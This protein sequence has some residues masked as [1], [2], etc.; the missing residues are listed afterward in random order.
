MRFLIVVLY[1]D[2]LISTCPGEIGRVPCR[3]DR[4]R[5]G[6]RAHRVLLAQHGYLYIGMYQRLPLRIIGINHHHHPPPPI[7]VY[8]DGDVKNKNRFVTYLFF[9]FL[10]RVTTRLCDKWESERDKSR[11]TTGKAPVYFRTGGHTSTHIF[12]TIMIIIMII[13]IRV[14]DD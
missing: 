3:R 2:V 9:F 13:M 6:S 10:L 7:P 12:D 11:D 4:L 8:D 1:D 14:Y 5:P